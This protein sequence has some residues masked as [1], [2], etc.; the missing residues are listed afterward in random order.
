MLIFN[1]AS[2][3]KFEKTIRRNG[4]LFVNTSLVHEAPTR[5]D[6]TRIEVKAN[7]I[8]EQLGDI[9]VSNMVMLGAFLKKTGVVALDSV[10]AALREVL[11]QRRHS[12]MPLNENALKRG[13]Q[14]CS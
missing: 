1:E 7:D 6:L 8:A 3:K 12:L 9:R 14:V 4:Q 10:L 11:P 13:A 5:E 2:F